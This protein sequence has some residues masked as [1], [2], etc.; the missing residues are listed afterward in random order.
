MA[1]RVVIT[2]RPPDSPRRKRGEPYRIQI[3]STGHNGT[4]AERRPR[5]RAALQD[6]QSRLHTM[7]FSVYK[8]T[9][10]Q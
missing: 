6:A 8:P 2:E 3:K 1:Y 10:L 4:P 5:R 9:E 7:G